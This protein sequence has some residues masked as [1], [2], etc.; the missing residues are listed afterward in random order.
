MP[1]NAAIPLVDGTT[2]DLILDTGRSITI[3]GPNGSGKSALSAFLQRVL[4]DSVNRIFAHRRLW[5]NSSAPEMSPAQRLSYRENFDS[6]DMQLDSRW[7]DYGDQYRA[8]AIMVDL[9]ERQNQV[10]G[11]IAD[12]ARKGDSL[13][14]VDLTGPLQILNAIMAAASLQVRVHIS[15]SS[16]LTCTRMSGETYP[17]AEMSD[18]EKAALLLVADVLV[19]PRGSIHLVDEPE[20]HLHRSISASLIASLTQ[21]CT[22]DTFV[23]FTHDLELAQALS[24]AGETFVTAGCTWQDKN[25]VA[26]DLRIVP[27][28]S[29]L[30]EELRRAVLGG[31]AQV[32]FHEGVVGGLDQQ[33]YEAL[34]A[35]QTVAPVGNCAAVLRAVAGLRDS[36]P[37][38]WITASGIVDKDFRR[39][40]PPEG[41]CQLAL[42]EIENIFYARLALRR[43]AELQ[44]DALGLVADVL[45]EGALKARQAALTVPGVRSNILSR[46]SL[47]YARDELIDKAMSLTSVHDEVTSVAV[48]LLP[49]REMEDEYDRLLGAFDATDEFLRKFPIRESG[50]RARVAAEL[51]FASADLYER[52]VI[53][54]LR[55]I[56]EFRATMLADLGLAH[57]VAS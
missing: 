7:R 34:L 30:P 31:R 19:A 3:V 17:A 26:W 1:R 46:R 53:Q 35:G 25:P 39:D 57:L 28:A 45:E 36:A 49:S 15:E 18:G 6:W 32:V 20:R 44:A 43:M 14:G 5:L 16:E 48:S 21:T 23:I 22:E 37:L 52:A 8:P 50:M 27:P 4:P 2:L 42:H 38:H 51:K 54:Q 40:A 55:Q 33:V 47:Q 24:S 41:V 56:P 9:I 12:R 10:N 13:D 29:S 11:S